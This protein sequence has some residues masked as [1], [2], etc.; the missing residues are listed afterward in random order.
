MND[1]GAQCAWDAVTAALGVWAP[2]LELGC[3]TGLRSFPVAITSIALL[4]RQEH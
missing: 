1:H 4:Y 2:T 3:L